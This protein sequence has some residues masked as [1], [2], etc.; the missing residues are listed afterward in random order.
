[1]ILLSVCKLIS[2]NCVCICWNTVNNIYKQ[3]KESNNLH[4]FII[5]GMGA[6]DKG[7]QSAEYSHSARATVNITLAAR[8]EQS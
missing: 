5:P 7:P 1:M 2:L 6:Y 8:S 4:A 3:T